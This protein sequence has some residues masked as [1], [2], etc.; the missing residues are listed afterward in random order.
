MSVIDTGSGVDPSQLR[1]ELDGQQVETTYDSQQGL[2]WYI[3]NPRGAARSLANGVRNF[4]I[5]ATDWLGNEATAQ[6]SFTVDNSLEPPGPRV[7]T[8]GAGG[9]MP[10][11]PE[12]PGWPGGQGTGGTGGQPPQDG[13]GGPAHW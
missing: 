12:G 11:G 13:Q 8:P 6:A 2:L 4:V 1:L 3:Y 9:E 5:T 10:G 7:P